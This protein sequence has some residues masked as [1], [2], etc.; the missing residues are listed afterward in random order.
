MA[1]SLTSE[2]ERDKRVHWREITAFSYRILE[3]PL[4]SS[5][6]L[7]LGSREKPIEFVANSIS[8]KTNCSTHENHQLVI[9]PPLETHI[10]NCQNQYHQTNSLA[11]KF[12]DARLADNLR[13]L[14]RYNF[15][16]ELFVRIRARNTSLFVITF[17]TYHYGQV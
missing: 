17:D 13:L 12:P 5:S 1:K 14:Y 4:L 9:T 15:R 6:H 2:A 8:R 10:T 16:S 11:C 7:H 3:K